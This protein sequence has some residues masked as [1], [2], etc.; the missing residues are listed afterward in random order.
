[1]AFRPPH[2]DKDPYPSYSSNYG[3]N[4]SS[5]GSQSANNQMSE[6][7]QEANWMAEAGQNVKT[8]NVDTW[9]NNNDNANNNN[10][11]GNNNNNS[12]SNTNQ[13]FQSDV[14][15]GG[16]TTNSTKGNVNSSPFSGI[17]TEAEFDFAP[18]EPVTSST[19][20]YSTS[21]IKK[22]IDK[23]ASDTFGNP[24]IDSSNDEVQKLYLAAKG[25]AE[26]LGLDPTKSKNMQIALN[27][28]N[29]GDRIWGKTERALANIDASTRKKIEDI[30]GASI[31]STGDWK[32]WGSGLRGGLETRYVGYLG[33]EKDYEQKQQILSGNW[34]T[35]SNLYKY[36]QA[37]V[38]A[39]KPLRGADLI[40]QVI[41]VAF[42]ALTGVPLSAAMAA[43]DKKRRGKESLLGQFLNVDDGVGEDGI[44]KFSVNGK[45]ISI[46]DS[47]STAGIS[48][49]D[50]YDSKIG[51]ENYDSETYSN[52]YYN[53]N[54][55]DED[56]DYQLPDTPEE[57]EDEIEFSDNPAWWDWTLF[58]R[59]FGIRRRVE[60]VTDEEDEV[61]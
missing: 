2:S 19:Q 1:M 53:S 17:W 18:S 39:N 56:D 60:S 38:D 23:Y 7:Q 59:M 34:D 6:A 13:S 45:D 50:I 51:N 49:Y 29:G 10:N 35:S 48:K 28:L 22:E 27:I 40:G 30:K 58:E 41:G 31:E 20:N 5:T 57:D 55:P 24:K 3:S 46:N 16:Q 52:Y 32:T 4:N 42:T 36:Q 11:S 12:N 44:F 15:T 37:L 61:A 25:V 21:Q 8:T 43:E 14:S 47:I 33:D 54:L 9:T 26:T